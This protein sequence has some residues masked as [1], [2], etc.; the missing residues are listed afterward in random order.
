MESQS[1]KT[2]VFDFDGTL[3]DTL[4]IYPKAFA[5]GYQLLVDRGLAPQKSFSR[6]EAARNIGLTTRE[7]WTTLLPDLPDEAW[8]AAAK[9]V[10]ESLDALMASGEAQLFDGIPTMLDRVRAAGLNCV[11]LSNCR[12][13]YQEA[14]RKAFGLDTWFSAY[15]NAEEFHGEPKERMFET[16]RTQHEGGFI[17]VGDR[18]KDRTFAHAHNLL[19]VGCLYGCGTAEEL[20]G[21][22]RLVHTPQ[23]VA[24]ALLDLVARGA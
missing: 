18:S 17:A 7:A 22:T 16:I 15:Y 21:A 12:T 2:V 3:H 9:R 6:D 24:D 4:H 5:D 20:A 19:F 1:I 14:A 10:G 13:S 8:I 11:F 23:E